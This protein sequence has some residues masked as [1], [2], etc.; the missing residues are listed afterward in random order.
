[1]PLLTQHT[2]N[3]TDEHPYPQGNSNL[4][5]QKSR[6]CDIRLRHCTQL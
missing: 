6:S 4:R 3:T 1:M 5:F 2:T